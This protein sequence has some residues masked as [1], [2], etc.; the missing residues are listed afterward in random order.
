MWGTMRMIGVGCFVW[1]LCLTALSNC[2]ECD[3]DV[4][5]AQVVARAYVSWR[6]EGKGAVT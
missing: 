2:L 1:M 6:W 4:R 5:A 3:V